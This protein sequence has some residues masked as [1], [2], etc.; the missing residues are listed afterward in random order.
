MELHPV[1]SCATNGVRYILEL[2]LE[3]RQV[4]PGVYRT[5]YAHLVLCEEQQVLS[6]I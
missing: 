5:F 1:S 2:V 4:S 6:S 3:Y